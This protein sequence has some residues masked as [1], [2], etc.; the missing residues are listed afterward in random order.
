[1]D[2][3]LRAKV[4]E[5]MASGIL[6][7]NLPPMKRT[8]PGE[9]IPGAQMLIGEQPEQLCTVCEERGPQVAYIYAG[10]LFIVRLHTDCDELW[11]QERGVR[12]RRSTS[13]QP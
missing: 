3:E 8:G 5:L 7:R 9:G 1:M 11:Q 4:R 12:A 6:P 13:D 10:E 2:A